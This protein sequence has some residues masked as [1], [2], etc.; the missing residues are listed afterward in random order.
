[1]ILAAIREK[2]FDA[3]SLCLIKTQTAAALAIVFKL[4][5]NLQRQGDE[6]DALVKANN[7]HLNTGFVGTPILCPALS[8]TGHNDTAVTV[9][10][11]EDF[12]SW[13]YSV[14]LGATT[15]WE[16]WNSVLPDGHMNP[17]G[18]NSL[19]HYT[20]GS[21][22]SWIVSWLCG[23]RPA[24]PGYRKVILE[25]RP[26]RRLG[27]AEARLDT[28]AGRFVCEWRYEGEEP[29]YHVEIPFGAT[30][31]LRLPGQTARELKAGI[32]DC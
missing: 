10:L 18:M 23:V 3:D 13:L 24:L 6:L 4:T 5:E 7:K 17:E 21:I 1:M 28:A 11:Q 22:V 25:P 29:H 8:S 31:E 2:Y 30:A 26:D 9:L 27:H 12:P 14:K 20:Y 15:I 19:N 32:Y 16:R